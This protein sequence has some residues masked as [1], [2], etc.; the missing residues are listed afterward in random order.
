MT[1][2][3][4][5]ERKK[6]IY[7]KN[8]KKL[9]IGITI[10][11]II[12]LIAVTLGKKIHIDNDFFLASFGTHTIMFTLSIMA[13][14]L[15]RKEVNYKLKFPKIST[16]FKPF[17]IALITTILV[18]VITVG[19]T[20]ILGAKVDSHP[21]FEGSTGWQILI[22]VFF[23]ASI[24]E[25]L[26][27]R[28]F[29][30]NYIGKYSSKGINIFNKKISY[31][32]IISGFAFGLAHLIL[33]FSNV[34]GLFVA[35]IVIFTISLGIIAGYYQEKYDNNAYAI[36]VHMTGNLLGVIAAFA[37]NFAH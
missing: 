2:V 23:Y 33:L 13:I 26:L 10:T 11:I 24:A 25:E 30:L 28:G 22:F 12:Y 15:L 27:F 14:Y 19:L 37:M 35:R 17:I 3:G 36:F 6:Q 34:N 5:R 31:P 32:V 1:L 16:I 20:K 29:L 7:M 21:I 9:L 4:S 8:S 18:N